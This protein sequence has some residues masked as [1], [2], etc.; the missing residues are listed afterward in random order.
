LIEGE[1]YRVV[2]TT[3]SGLYRYDL[4]DMVTCTAI[5][6]G[7]PALRFAGRGDG[8]SDLVGEKLT[9]S[10]VAAALAAL[11]A[12][13]VLVA[14][15]E[16]PG[17]VLVCEAALGGAT[18]AGMEGRLAANPQYAHARAIGQLAPLRAVHR[19]HLF[20]DLTQAALA[21]GRRM[22]DLKPVALL[23]HGAGGW[24]TR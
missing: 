1:A 18:L 6:S 3:A 12:P 14:A 5:R 10:F 2:V 4:G 19:P 11:P 15:H 16:P 9:E 21:A 23:D 22:G 7:V 17:Y 8:V 13:A 24:L 20:R